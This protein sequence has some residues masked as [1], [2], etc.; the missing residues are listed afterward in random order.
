MRVL[1]ALTVIVGCGLFGLVR[2][3]GLRNQ[4]RC[5]A[6]VID[7]LR[8]MG[9]ELKALSPPL[10]ELMS[11]LAES[12]RPEVRGFY[13]KLRAATELLG[14]ES[15]EKLWTSAVM[16]DKTLLLNENQRRELCKA[17]AFIGRFSAQ[18][19]AVALESCIS[20]L[21][22]EYRMAAEKAREGRRLYPGLGLT[23]GIMLAAV[24]I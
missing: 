24:F 14:D 20:R 7:S 15:F 10:P 16:T 17:G 5:I 13:E 22:T 12:A 19:Q 6:A 8:Y 4:E 18:E 21:E 1:G 2:A 23:A 3:I 9:S 11:E